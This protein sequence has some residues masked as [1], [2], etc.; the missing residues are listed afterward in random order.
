MKAISAGQ[1]VS[2]AAKNK[3]K[4]TAQ[5]ETNTGQLEERRKTRNTEQ[6]IGRERERELD[7][8]PWTTKYF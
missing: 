4:A 5:S 7:S 6:V 2:R 8:E 3:R 1:Q